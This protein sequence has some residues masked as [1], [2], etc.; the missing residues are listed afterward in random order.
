M[1]TG[2]P[3][4]R[5]H[6]EGRI[7]IQVDEDNIQHES[8]TRR[9]GRERRNPANPRSRATE[10]FLPP[11]PH[12]KCHCKSR[13]QPYD[14]PRGSHSRTTGQRDATLQ[15]SRWTNAGSAEEH[16]HNMGN[17]RGSPAHGRTPRN[18]QPDRRKGQGDLITEASLRLKLPTDLAP[19]DRKLVVDAAV[20]LLNDHNKCVFGGEESTALFPALMGKCMHGKCRRCTNGHTNMPTD[21]VFDDGLRMELFRQAGVTNWD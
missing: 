20:C 16:A 9:G 4:H 12:R 6:A 14:N 8:G 5:L 13:H 19:Y 10:H 17:F 3:K 11:P 2:G 15:H 21:Y 7:S 18:Q 1:G